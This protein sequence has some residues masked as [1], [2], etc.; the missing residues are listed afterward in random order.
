M[1]GGCQT[2]NGTTCNSFWGYTAQCPGDKPVDYGAG[3]AAL[4]QQCTGPNMLYL[5]PGT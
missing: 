1:I 3:K 5:P 4:M 2:G